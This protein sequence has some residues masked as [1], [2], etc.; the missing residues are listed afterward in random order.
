MIHEINNNYDRA[1]S[2]LGEI[3]NFK[4]DEIVN[5]YTHFENQPIE[6]DPKLSILFT[7]DLCFMLEK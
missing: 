5:Y 3:F 1:S 2:H 7:K 4:L 6:K